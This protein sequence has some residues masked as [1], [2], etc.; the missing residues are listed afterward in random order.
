MN[1]KI[2]KIEKPNYLKFFETL[3]SKNSFKDLL[4]M[5]SDSFLEICDTIEIHYKSLNK[6]GIIR[7]IQYNKET[8]PIRYAL[9]ITLF[10]LKQYPVDK[11]MNFLFGLHPIAIKRIIKKICVCIL[12]FYDHLVCWPSPETFQNLKVFST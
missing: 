12:K 1:K 6:D 8:I 5:E 7:K 10:W 9:M 2:E 3:D 11:V 4:N